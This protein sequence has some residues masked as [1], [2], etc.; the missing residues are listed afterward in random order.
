M[1][2]TDDQVQGKHSSP[3]RIGF[4]PLHLASVTAP[5]APAHVTAAARAAGAAYLFLSG[6]ELRAA[7]EQKTSPG[8][9]TQQ[10]SS[11]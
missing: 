5:A 10:L 11:F 8:R 7:P 4:F 3:F 2:P 6:E 9:I 1:N